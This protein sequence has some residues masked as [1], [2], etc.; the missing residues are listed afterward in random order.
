VRHEKICEIR[1]RDMDGFGHVN[2]GTLTVYFE[3]ARDEYFGLV[4]GSED[5]VMRL[6]VRRLE[7][8]YLSQLSQA[9]DEVRVVMRVRS[10]GRTSVTT[11]EELYARSDGRL[12]ATASCVLVRLD[13]GFERPEEFP[14]PLRARLEAAAEQA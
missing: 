8:D 2:H 13:A 10:I 5:E 7:I 3:E 1:W 14:P 9:D 4:L 11:E 6:V 12:A